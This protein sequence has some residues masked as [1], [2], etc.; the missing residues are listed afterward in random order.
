MAEKST[1]YYRL[2]LLILSVLVWVFATVLVLAWWAYG[3]DF[4]AS[5]FKHPGVV[6]YSFTE[7]DQHRTVAIVKE[8]RQHLSPP[9]LKDKVVHGQSQNQPLG[10]GRMYDNHL[11][12]ALP[13]DVISGIK[14]VV[15][16]VGY[17]RSGH[18]IIGS[19][20]DAHPNVVI[21]HEYNLFGKLS[22]FFASHSARGQTNPT[23]AVK[24]Q[25][26][27]E[28]Y[29]NSYTNVFLNGT[30]NQNIK[31]YNLTLNGTW[32]GRYNDQILVIG[33]KSGAKSTKLYVHSSAEFKRIYKLL[34]SIKT[35]VVIFHCVRNPF[36][37]ISTQTLFISHFVPH[38]EPLQPF[39][40]AKLNTTDKFRNNKILFKNINYIFKLAGSVLNMTNSLFNK[41]MVLEVHNHEFVSNPEKTVYKLCQFLGILCSPDY[42][43]SCATKVFPKVSRTR[44]A[45]DWP[46]DLKLM[47]ERRLD[48]YPFFKRYSFNSSI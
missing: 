23:E 20:L 10:Y 28:I 41:S 34:E 47:V 45:V 16:F 37:I 21:G 39:A 33:D 7:T 30:R 29:Q 1:L 27:N 43:R 26:F 32:Q 48:D 14:K 3:H 9:F 2:R 18:S 22:Q 6:Q 38:N 36:D 15:I 4:K 25:L 31:G 5:F 19:I 42:V 11:P 8:S 35:P 17:P 13:Q 44:F 40:I 46:E 12:S 24:V